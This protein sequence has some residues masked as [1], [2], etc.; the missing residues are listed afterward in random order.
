MCCLEREGPVEEFDVEISDT[1]AQIQD[2]DVPTLCELE[3]TLKKLNINRTP[4]PDGI[5]AELF[6]VN[7][8]EL[9]N[10]LLKENINVIFLEVKSTVNQIHKLRQ[11]L[12][13]TEEYG[14]DTN[15]LF[16]DFKATYDCINR[17][18]LFETMCELGNSPKLTDLAK[19]TL[20]S[21]KCCRVKLMSDVSEVFYT[22]RGLRQ[23]DSLSCISFNT[24][25]EKVI[26]DSGINTILQRSIQ[27][28]A[29]AD[30]ID[31]VGRTM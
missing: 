28:L 4:D 24:A 1:H 27:L 31:I 15:H 6:N 8:P 16:V 30:D 23:G 10:E 29:Y 25:L 9:N 14:I 5:K 19:M 22:E 7:A 13:K 3:Y 2:D 17:L 18:K 26:R 20:R 12:E 11:I 21:V